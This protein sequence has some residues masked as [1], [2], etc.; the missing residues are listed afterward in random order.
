MWYYTQGGTNEIGWTTSWNPPQAHNLVAWWIN[1]QTSND[2]VTGI[3]PDTSGSANHGSQ[4]SAVCRPAWDSSVGGCLDFDGVND[5]VDLTLWPPDA[6]MCV[7]GST[8]RAAWF[9]QDEDSAEANLSLFSS[10]DAPDANGVD[11]LVST[12]NK[13]VLVINRKTSDAGSTVLNSVTNGLWY[14]TAWTY[15]QSTGIHVLYLNGLA[16]HTWTNLWDTL[17]VNTKCEPLF[18]AMFVS[19]MEY[20]WHGKMSDMM[21]YNTALSAAEVLDLKTGTAKGR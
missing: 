8:T 17:T 21:I 20:F 4:A 13:H 5:W 14:H 3:Y 9:L 7:T 6:R 16:A 12:P 18:A 10:R 19:G 11:W 2:A 1:N 15:D